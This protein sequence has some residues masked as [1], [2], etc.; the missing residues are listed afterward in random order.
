MEKTISAASNDSKNALE[1]MFGDKESFMTDVIGNATDEEAFKVDEGVFNGGPYMGLIRRAMEIVSKNPRYEQQVLDRAYKA[2]E[3]AFEDLDLTNDFTS[4]I[5]KINLATMQFMKI[6]DICMKK[7]KKILP[8]IAKGGSTKFMRSIMENHDIL[9]QVVDKKQNLSNGIKASVQLKVAR[10]YQKVN[11]D[12]SFMEIL[13]FGQTLDKISEQAY[14]KSKRKESIPP[15]RGTDRTWL[16]GRGR[17]GGRGTRNGESHKPRESAC[18]MT[19]DSNDDDEMIQCFH[20]GIAR[21]GFREPPRWF[22]LLPAMRQA[23]KD[24]DKDQLREQD[25]KNAKKFKCEDRWREEDRKYFE[26]IKKG[27]Y[28]RGAVAEQTTVSAQLAEIKKYAKRIK[29]MES[30]WKNT[31]KKSTPSTKSQDDKDDSEAE[32][33]SDDESYSSDGSESSDDLFSASDDESHSD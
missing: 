25:K 14:A 5:R 33:S 4:I 6:Q 2:M 16:N 11:D 8:K 7:S 32:S 1:K 29:K 31:Q 12:Y 10:E 13:A 26:H 21:P 18:N 27:D 17:G 20:K 19:S 28:D 15:S 23:G 30:N 9:A 24:I 22:M 3:E